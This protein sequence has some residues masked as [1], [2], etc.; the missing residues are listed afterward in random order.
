MYR[1]KGWAGLRHRA[2]GAAI[3]AFLAAAAS[4]ILAVP[5][6]LRPGALSGDALSFWGSVAGAALGS[7]LAVIG[8][9]WVEERKRLHQTDHERK[10]LAQAVDAVIQ[11]LDTIRTV[12]SGP[13]FDEITVI[14]EYEGLLDAADTLAFARERFMPPSIASYRHLKAIESEIRGLDLHMARCSS[15]KQR[16]GLTREK[17]EEDFDKLLELGKLLDTPFKVTLMRLAA[18]D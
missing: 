11:H 7:G 12:K 4:I 3:G 16:L 6:I 2:L 9:V 15:N 18:A 13:E 5:L 17:V 14:V 1:G 10:M 8:A